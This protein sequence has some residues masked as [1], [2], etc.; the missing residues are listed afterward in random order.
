MSD[1]PASPTPSVTTERKS[2]TIF[3]TLGPGEHSDL[4]DGVARP[5]LDVGGQRFHMVSF[6]GDEEGGTAVLHR[7][8]TTMPS[9]ELAERLIHAT[10]DLVILSVDWSK[11]VNPAEVLTGLLK[12]T[13]TR[14][15][16]NYTQHKHHLATRGKP[17]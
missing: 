3:D 8:Q 7:D 14:F 5:I 6:I 17:S 1:K 11:G 15:R 2:H 4:P 12:H 10:C 13:A 16:D 9:A